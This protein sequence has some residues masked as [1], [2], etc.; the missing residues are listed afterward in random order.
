MVKSK[1]NYDTRLNIVCEVEGEVRARTTDVSGLLLV[2]MLEHN[3]P[4]LFQCFIVI[5]C[6]ICHKI[7]W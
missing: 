2:P 1:Y 4:E 7:E 3:G 5:V 6:T